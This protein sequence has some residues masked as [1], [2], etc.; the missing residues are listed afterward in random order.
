MIGPTLLASF[1]NFIHLLETKISSDR[2][3]C[4]ISNVSDTNSVC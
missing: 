1:N 4:D 3:T 2:K